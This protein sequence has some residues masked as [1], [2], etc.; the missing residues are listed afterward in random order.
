MLSPLLSTDEPERDVTAARTH[1]C[2]R[3]WPLGCIVSVVSVALLITA[4]AKPN[5]YRS[6]VDLVV[7]EVTFD[8]GAFQVHAEP[9]AATAS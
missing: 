3:L 9:S 1:K 8:V 6:T 4:A 7:G 2:T 5:V